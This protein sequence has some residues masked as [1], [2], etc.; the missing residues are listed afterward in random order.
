MGRI[1]VLSMSTV[2]ATAAAKH[3]N[4]K[5]ACTAQSHQLLMHMLL[6]HPPPPLEG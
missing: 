5:L 3:L 1:E 6:G 2:A 4:A